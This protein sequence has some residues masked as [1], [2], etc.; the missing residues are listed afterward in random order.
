MDLQGKRA[1][2]VAQK[3]QQLAN[4]NATIGAIQVVDELIVEQAAETS[5]QLDAIAKQMAREADEAAAEVPPAVDIKDGDRL[6]FDDGRQFTAVIPAPEMLPVQRDE[7][8]GHVD[9]EFPGCDCDGPAP[10]CCPRL[11]S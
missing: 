5:R 2:L 8:C 9:C 4:L 3:D 1:L 7:G 11:A 10:F 6:T